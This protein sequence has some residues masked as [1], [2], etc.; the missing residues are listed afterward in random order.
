MMSDATLRTPGGLSGSSEPVRAEGSAGARGDHRARAG[1]ALPGALDARQRVQAARRDLLEPGPAAAP[2]DT[3]D[4][5]RLGWTGL[6][7]PF[8]AFFV[9]SL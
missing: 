1:D 3:L 8:G 7:I 9:N 5:W 4:N 6:G 2:A